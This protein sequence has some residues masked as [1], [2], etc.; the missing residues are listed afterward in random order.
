MRFQLPLVMLCTVLCS[1]TGCDFSTGTSGDGPIGGSTTGPSGPTGGPSGRCFESPVLQGIDG[2]E[3]EICAGSQITLNGLNF[4]S[5]PSQNEVLFRGANNV[6]VQGI[7]LQAVFP[8]DGDCSNGLESRLI[9][10]VPGGAVS[11][12]LELRVRGVFAGGFGYSA[13]PQIMA[14]EIGRD[15]S[16][17]SLNFVDLLGTFDQ[18]AF[19]RIIGTNFQSLSEIVL[20]DAQ[21]TRARIPA[22]SLERN[23][24]GVGAQSGYSRVGFAL[25]DENTEVRLLIQGPRD[26]ISVQAVGQTAVS[27]SVQV[28][29]TVQEEPELVLNGVKVP[30]GGV[31]GGVRIRYSLYEQNVSA[32]YN[33]LVEWR[34]LSALS[35]QNTWFTAAPDTSDSEH[36]NIEGILPGNFAR[37]VGR[38]L[39]PVRGAMRTFTWNPALDANFPPNGGQVGGAQQR[40]WP[41]EFRISPQ[42]GA[43]SR[44]PLTQ[45]LVT[46]AILYVDLS[47]DVLLEE[48]RDQRRATFVEPFTDVTGQLLSETTAS[49]AVP[50]G[51]L[52]GALPEE[53]EEPDVFGQGTRDLVLRPP[54][55]EDDPKDQL[56]DVVQEFRIDTT[57][58]RITFVQTSLNE[59]LDPTD[60][61]IQTARVNLDD[62]PGEDEG[63]FHFRTLTITAGT[64]VIAT[65]DKPLIIR[66]SGTDNPEE[67]A[68]IVEAGAI[69]DLSGDDGGLSPRVQTGSNNAEFSPGRGGVAGA[70]GGDGGNGADIVIEDASSPIVVNI[71]EAGTGGNNGGGGGETTAAL[72][73]GLGA[74][75]NTS[76]I[77]GGPGGGGGGRFRGGDG[78]PGMPSPIDYNPA[79]GGRGGDARGDL[80]LLDVGAAAGSGGGGGGA[81]LSGNRDGEF[82]PVGGAGGGG[83]GGALAVICNGSMVIT[84]SVRAD[85]GD[86]GRGNNR[87][88]PP[89]GTA[90]GRSTGEAAPGAGGAG[91][92]GAILLQATGSVDVG[93]SQLSVEGGRHGL[94][95]AAVDEFVAAFGD[96]NFA[97]GAGDG[98]PG[99]IRVEANLGGAPT[100]AV[101]RAETT[102]TTALEF[103]DFDELVVEDFSTFPQSGTIRVEG[104]IT[105][106]DT[107]QDVPVTEEM[108]YDLKLFDEELLESKLAKLRRSVDGQGPFDFRSGS[109]VILKTGLVPTIDGSVLSEGSIVTAPGGVAVPSGREGDLTFPYVAS[110]DRETGVPILDEVTGAQLSIYSMNTD[111]GIITDP[112]GGTFRAPLRQSTN[113]TNVIDV[114]QL[115]IPASVV[116]KASGSLP[117]QIFV[118]ERADIAGRIDVSGEPGGLMR[119]DRDDL[120]APLPGPGGRGGPAGG[121]GGAGG[122]IAYRDGDVTN[123]VAANTVAVVAEPGHL[124]GNTP[125]GFAVNGTPVG[126]GGLEDE[127]LPGGNVTLP[128][129]GA[130]VRATGCG[131]GE[132]PTP[133]DQTAGGGAGGSNLTGG[134]AGESLPAGTSR[135]GASGSPFGVSNFRVADGLFLSGGSGGS[136]GGGNDQVSDDYRAGL[137][138]D[139]LNQARAL[140]APGTGGGGGA[141]VLHIVCGNL[142]LRS[143]AQIQAKGGDAF[144]TIDLGGN[145]GAGAGGNLIFQVRETVTIEPG[146]TID[147]SGGTANRPPPFATGIDLPNY[148]GNIRLVGEFSQT[149]MNFGGLGGDGA[150][151]RVRIEVDGDSLGADLTRSAPNPSFSSGRFF[152][153]RFQSVAVSQPIQLGVGNSLL[154]GSPFMQLRDPIVSFNQ[155]GEPLGTAATVLWQGADESLDVHAGVGEFSP[156]TQDVNS[157]RDRA[158]VRF[159]VIF[160]SNFESD[161]RQSIRS[162]SLPYELILPEALPEEDIF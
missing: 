62:V 59:P 13:C 101:L 111:T 131:Q 51:T 94:S 107:G 17:P 138:G 78:D 149:L 39:L 26:N 157:L 93:C 44:R 37:M 137:A 146:A 125:V 70:G 58:R 108:S 114:L 115:R 104:F 10:S 19:V 106:P 74:T 127:L 72:D 80:G 161:D 29:A 148:E 63:E 140:L 98:S 96:Q 89:G 15:G 11:G 75:V 86:G 5:D 23:V 144:Q 139:S 2:I 121:D 109:R 36:D 134:V 4:A 3:E 35:N 40:V 47:D 84:G 52:Q 118:A 151:G 147:V 20:E 117:L 159:R 85:G 57:N 162:I 64:R 1:L 14:F 67:P 43:G 128:G 34:P 28:P 54:A 112:E 133:C 79:R 136:G 130:T 87:I 92:G 90:N 25:N 46:P 82:Q 155:F 30:T 129:A 102:T 150:P 71:V 73:F 49:W 45:S 42:Q 69:L 22:N 76:Q 66:L 160:E 142:F 99:W 7:P 8:T 41:L 123:N 97:P 18:N 124:P 56:D 154:V 65:G 103:D 113:P 12:N 83:G 110:F 105:D 31:S 33:M 152:P 6:R 53:G 153:S 91:S 120:R 145:A 38:E 143:T 27:N 81:A 156:P 32:S 61:T 21:G 68:F 9:V 158:Y 24:S 135:G 132:D 122:T 50:T 60:D 119:F 116:L 126:D 48:E 141:G 77:P 55:V 16:S 100:C 88:F 95:A